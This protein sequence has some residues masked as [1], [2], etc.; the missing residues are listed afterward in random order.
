M[1]KGKPKKKPKKP[2]KLVEW[3]QKQNLEQIRETTLDLA[4][5]VLGYKAFGDLKG[6][7]LAVISRRLAMTRGGTPPIAQ[8]AGVTGLSIV[9]AG[10]LP[11]TSETD[12]AFSLLG[13]VSPLAGIIDLLRRQ[14]EAP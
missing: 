12:V 10:L 4:L 6:S 2:S 1:V 7:V 5:A 11:K 13:T 9:G 8:I 14:A 3:F